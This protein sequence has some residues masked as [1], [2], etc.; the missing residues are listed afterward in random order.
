MGGRGW[1]LSTMHLA[2]AELPAMPRAALASTGPGVSPEQG[3]HS[4]LPAFYFLPA[5][6]SHWHVPT[7]SQSTSV[8]DLQPPPARCWHVPQPPPL[9]SK[10]GSVFPAGTSHTGWDGKGF[11]LSN[12]AAAGVPTPRGPSWAR[13]EAGSWLGGGG[14]GSI[15]G[16]PGATRVWQL[17]HCPY[18]FLWWMNHW[19]PWPGSVAPPAPA[20]APAEAGE[21]VMK[22]GFRHGPCHQ[23]LLKCRARQPWP[24][25]REMETNNHFNFTG[26]SSAP[27][28]SGP[29]PTPASGDSPF[30]HSSPLGFPLQGKS[31]NGGMNVNGFSTVSHPGTS[32]TFSPGSA[33]AGA[34]PLRAYDCLWDYT[35]YAAAG[36][37]KDGGPPALGQFPLN[38]VAGG[39]R[40]ASPGHGTNLRAAGQDFWGNGTAGPMGLNFDSQEL[41]DSFH[42]QSFELMQNGPDGFYAAGQSSPILSSDTQSFPLA[43]DEPDPGQGDTDSAAKEMPTTIAENGGGLVGS[44]ELEEAQPD[45]KI[46][47]YNGAAAGAGSLGPEGPVLAPRDRGCLGDASPIA[48]RLEDTHILSEDP[49]EPFESLAR[50]RG[51]LGVGAVETKGGHV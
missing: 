39:S 21:G 9:T 18:G 25:Q 12:P 42:D 38:G 10:A 35:P 8:C 6:S 1:P 32:G 29:K 45:L 3:L 2:R 40:P 23:P 14:C 44:Q 36:G 24:F 11:S 33:P 41:Y 50:G 17:R 43:P 22:S 27:A 15:L 34:Q 31:L 4:H 47:S 13:A 37:L 16:C 28:A 20:R 19:W 30:T 49:L 7:P 48:P 26:L 46:C 51:A 5:L